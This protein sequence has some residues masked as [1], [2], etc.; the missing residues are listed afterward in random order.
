MRADS[1]IIMDFTERNITLK[2]SFIIPTVDRF[3]ELNQCIAS[4]EKAYEYLNCDV[5]I[6]IIVI[7]NGG[8]L[9][10][11]L[12]RYPQLCK[13]FCVT[14]LGV[15][16]ARNYGIDKS[17]GNYLIFTDDDATIK[18][19]F[20]KVLVSN[21]LICNAPVI[22]GRL[23]R[24]D[25]CAPFTSI[26]KSDKP[27]YLNYFDYAHSGG[28]TLIV[29]AEVIK[30]LGCYNENFGPGTNYPAAEEMDL[31]FRLLRQRI[32]P[33]YFPQLVFFHPLGKVNSAE[34]VFSYAYAMGFVFMKN[35]L[36]DKQSFYLYV[37]IILNILFR[38]LARIL[39]SLVFPKSMEEKNKQWQYGAFVK[40][41]TN[42][43]F[44]YLL[45][46]GDLS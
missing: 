11:V 1:F 8:K 6:E 7:C 10:R 18:E 42:G 12:S 25:N 44:K 35:M 28:T 37:C 41:I 22:Y 3:F 20:L 31:F 5:Q 19:D 26:Y 23:L 32:H 15:S 14:E 4:I 43:I 21:A 9:P 39:Q 13:I 38:A 16:R 29:K 46:K 2:Y 24:Q 27:K 34:K 40:G 33:V 30:R 17:K 45:K 36:A